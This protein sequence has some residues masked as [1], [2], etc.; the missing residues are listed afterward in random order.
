MENR[1]LLFIPDISG[2][3]RFVNEIEIEH[4]R[5]IIQQL[6]E[7][8]INANQIGLE[9]SEIEGDAIL[10]YKFGNPPE[11]ATIYKQVERMFCDFH[12]HLIAY[13]HRR[14]CQCKPCVSAVDLSLKVVTH[15]G[16]FATYNVR[17]FSKLIGK[18]VIVAHQLL[19][20]DID[21]HEY[22]LVTKSLAPGEIP[23]GPAKWM[24]WNTSAKQTE[25]GEIPFV[26]T[27]LSQLKN[28]LP[29]DLPPHIEIANKAKMITV[30]RDYEVDVKTLCY[31]VVHFEF[32]HEWQVGLKAIDE[33]EHFLPGVGSRHRHV[34]DNGQIVMMY[35]SSFVYDPESKIM[36]S[37]TDE[38]KKS[39]LYYTIEKSGE[40]TSRLTLEYCIEKN[41]VK[42][43]LFNLT[44]KKK[45][46]SML[47]QSLQNLDKI[48]REMVL[49]LEF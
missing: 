41:A 26:Y 23:V 7:V 49:P 19:K 48:A 15:Y 44:E 29:P 33:V 42:Q 35:T 43:L 10:F 45:M 11:L 4:S 46:E 13:D 24:E 40:H 39:S 38:K 32:R 28:E 1:G 30:W 47:Q 3:T 37:E 2:F 36:F 22:W 34:L 16:E 21:K 6:L 8:L 31:T 25:N 9:V 5:H 17:Q 27:Q 14:I 12:Q 20:N 18:D